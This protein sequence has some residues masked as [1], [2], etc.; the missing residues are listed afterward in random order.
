[1]ETSGEKFGNYPFLYPFLPAK[2]DMNIGKLRHRRSDFPLVKARDRRV[3]HE[4]S[5]LILLGFGRRAEP[6]APVSV[7]CDFVSCVDRFPRN[8]SFDGNEISLLRIVLHV[9]F[10][11]VEYPA[12][13]P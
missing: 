8:L 11:T 5:V 13:A 12:G 6:Y 4:N 10:L 3:K 1:M 9:N 7:R 2:C